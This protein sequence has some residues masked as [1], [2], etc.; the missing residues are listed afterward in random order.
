MFN[1]ELEKPT[2]TWSY[3]VTITLKPTVR[4][5]TAEQQYDR[6]SEYVVKQIKE[7]F[8]GCLL[9]LCV[10]LTK[11]YDIHF[12]G[13]INFK[14]S[15]IPKQVRNY[16]KWFSD[17]F[18]G[19]KIIGFTLLKVITEHDVWNEYIHKTNVQFTEDTNRE[20][21]ISTP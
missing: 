10:E 5:Y 2:Y 6:F 20:P 18:R 14:I 8:P 1:G 15:E 12:H 4:R 7:Y 21:I 19:D 13:T 3:A 11:S 17:K 9:T 16:P